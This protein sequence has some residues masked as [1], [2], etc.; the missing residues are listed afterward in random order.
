MSVENMAQSMNVRHAINPSRTFTLIF[1]II[2]YLTAN[3]YSISICILDLRYL[4]SIG[5]SL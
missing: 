4:Q 3:I 1:T 2:G 5:K